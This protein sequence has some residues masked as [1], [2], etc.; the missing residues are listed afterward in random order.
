MHK[1]RVIS[2]DPI[3]RLEGHGR[4]H[5]FLDQQGE[6]I[7]A[8][9]SGTEFRGFEKF[10]EGRAAEEMPS[11][12]AKICGVCPT[13]HHIASSKALDDL[14]K[15]MPPEAAKKIR[16]LMYCAYIFEDHILH[17]YFLGGCDFIVGA[18]APKE[19]RNFTG[20]INKVGVEVV[21]RVIEIRKKTRAINSLISAS[22]LWP[23]CGLP[24]GVSKAL[25][26][27]NRS[28]IKQSCG[29]AVEFAAFTLSLFDDI[30]LKDPQ[31]LKLLRDESSQTYYM[32]LVDRNDRLN[33]YDGKL[34]VIGPQGDEFVK[35]EVRDYLKH[36]QERVEQSSYI[37]TLY[38][39]K[40]GWKGLVSGKESGIYRV[41][42][43][44]RLNVSSGMA[45]P[46]AH[47][48]YEKFFSLLEG[49]SLHSAFSYHW[50][51]LIEAMYA[52]ERMLELAQDPQL[53]SP[54][55]RSIPDA[56]PEE[57]FGVCEAARGTLIHHY[58]TDDKAIIQ[59]V[60]LIVATQ[61]NAAGISMSIK[62]AASRLIKKGEVSEGILNMVEMAFR[63]YDPCLACATHSIPGE[64][65][66]IVD[67]YDDK[68]A[69]IKTLSR[70]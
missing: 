23:V 67:I 25:T 41:G 31:Y 21:R 18:D 3:T 14:F 57:G 15:V 10:C 28:I 55:I 30:V 9:F 32:G 17:F 49:R 16:E 13:A 4:I 62:E 24:G 53:T 5:I 12:T 45:T 6:V 37:K 51:R 65:P 54:E 1:G 70:G 59:K 34:K 29:E 47:I 27:E 56:L 26:E 36:L 58:K 68:M 22:A 50:A 69:L 2:I 66:L 60:N 7:D 42:P 39:K 35:F 63:A 46:L 40:V 19:Q 64:M 11:L 44:A 33:F 38:L 61:N 20:L 8:T 52:A 48:E 43:L